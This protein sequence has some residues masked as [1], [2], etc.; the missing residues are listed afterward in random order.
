MEEN[1]LDEEIVWF[2]DMKK[3]IE[4]ILRGMVWFGW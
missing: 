1:H 4:V 3:V 2:G